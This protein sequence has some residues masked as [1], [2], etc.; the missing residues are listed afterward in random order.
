[1][2][3]RAMETVLYSLKARGDTDAAELFK[4]HAGEI[5]AAII[6][7]L[8]SWLFSAD[9][10]RSIL[11]YY[12]GDKL[13]SG[14]TPVGSVLQKLGS[15]LSNLVW[16]TAREYI[17]T[18]HFTQ[19]PSWGGTGAQS[20]T[21]GTEQGGSLAETLGTEDKAFT[22][23][24]DTI[25]ADYPEVREHIGGILQGVFSRLEGRSMDDAA[26]ESAVREEVEDYVKFRKNLAQDSE[27]DFP[28]IHYW[29]QHEDEVI[30]GLSASLKK[31]RDSHEL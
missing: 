14:R 3:A 19:S 8:P 31:I 4:Q 30:R 27:E 17:D 16:A 13:K 24:T 20:L 23:A 12:K 29:D 26:I 11:D 15:L 28:D 21:P 2:I 1:M 10:R 25:A 22:G 6:A 18:K 9:T 7:A 5:R